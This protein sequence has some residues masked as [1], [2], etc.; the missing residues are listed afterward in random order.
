MSKGISS[1]GRLK[2]CKD[3]QLDKD[4][5]LLNITYYTKGKVMVPGNEANLKSFEEAFPLLKTK[6]NTKRIS[7]PSGSEDDE[8]PVENP[9][10]LSISV[11][12]TPAS[13][14]NQLKERIAV[15][16]LDFAEFKELT[17][18]RLSDP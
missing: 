18:A 2:I 16:E 14:T 9:T 11:P 7:V 13:S 3:E 1:G 5:P 17:H 6:V 15:L 10:T 8:S 12:P 4:D